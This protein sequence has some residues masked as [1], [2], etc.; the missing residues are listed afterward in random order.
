MAQQKHDPAQELSGLQRAQAAAVAPG[1]THVE[2]HEDLPL[3]Q[4]QG[5]GVKL[6]KLEVNI[7]Y[8]VSW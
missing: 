1:L 4:Q 6:K 8:V 2:E 3:P 5:I 7:I